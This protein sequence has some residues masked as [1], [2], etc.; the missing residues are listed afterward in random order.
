MKCEKTRENRGLGLLRMVRGANGHRSKVVVRRKWV[1]IVV[2]MVL[3]RRELG[4]VEGKNQGEREGSAGCLLVVHAMV[5]H[6]G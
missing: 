3:G 5:W 6:R 4:D 2:R 1:A